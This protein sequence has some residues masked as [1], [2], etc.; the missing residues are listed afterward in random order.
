MTDQQDFLHLGMFTAEHIHHW[1]KIYVQGKSKNH[2][3][4]ATFL[5]FHKKIVCF[6]IYFVSIL[7]ICL[8]ICF[9][10]FFK[11]YFVFLY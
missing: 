2:V 11:V 10:D 7:K 5:T 1:K 8:K 6:N 9:V 3:Y 4:L